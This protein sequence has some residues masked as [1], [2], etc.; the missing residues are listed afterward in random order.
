MHWLYDCISMAVAVLF[1]PALCCP[2]LPFVFFDAL[3]GTG[4]SSGERYAIGSVVLFYDDEVGFGNFSDA[5]WAATLFRVELR[6]VAVFGKS[7]I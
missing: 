2:P 6:R 3:V 4:K 5:S 1:R 7:V